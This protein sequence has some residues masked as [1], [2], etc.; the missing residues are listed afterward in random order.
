MNDQRPS[1]WNVGDEANGYRWTGTT[2]ERIW[3]AGDQANGYRFDGTTWQP[4]PPTP[5]WQRGSSWVAV[6]IVILAVVIGLSAVVS[7]LRGDSRTS[8]STGS[9]NSTRQ[10]TAASGAWVPSGFQIAPDDPD[11]AF[12]YAGA[13]AAQCPSYAESCYKLRVVTNVSCP[14]GVYVAISQL[15]NAGNIVGKGNEITGGVRPG[16]IVLV[17]VTGLADAPKA[18]VSEMSCL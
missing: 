9:S 1:G 5:F 12:S 7:Q 13:D 16:E 11:L 2:W 6:G 15:D 17:A 18:R 14:G 4:I 8:T 10:P 3:K